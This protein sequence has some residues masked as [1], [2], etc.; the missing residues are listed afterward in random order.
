MYQADYLGGLVAGKMTK[1]NYIGVV[2]PFSIPQMV[3]EINA[4][5]IGARQVNP[6][7]EV[8]VVWTNSWFDPVKESLAT[9]A[10]L[11]SGADVICSLIGS[12]VP[13]EE[14]AKEGKYS[15][16][17]YYDK[18]KISP[19]YV[20]T[21]RVFHWGVFYVDCLKSVHDGTWKSQAYWGSYVY[22]NC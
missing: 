14:A 19:E 8:H 13:I 2:A 18:S 15:I 6:K 1:S 5:T 16:G 12:A 10:L 9:K 4:I 3:R 7:A 20:L 11:S 22:W 17:Y 21:S